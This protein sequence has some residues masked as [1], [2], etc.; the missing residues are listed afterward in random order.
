MVSILDNYE[1]AMQMITTSN[2]LYANLC[3]TVLALSRAFFGIT[4]ESHATFSAMHSL[5]PASL[6]GA[7]RQSIVTSLWGQE[8]FKSPE[9]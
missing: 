4:A 7:A 5:H 9:K 2:H 8:L 6:S 3:A 1:C